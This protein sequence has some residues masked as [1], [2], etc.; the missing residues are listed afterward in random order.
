M[1]CYMQT[2]CTKCMFLIHTK[3]LFIILNSDSLRRL[4]MLLIKIFTN[5]YNFFAKYLMFISLFITF[6][7]LLT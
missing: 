3:D 2:Y 7:T 1:A 6:S 4:F 5:D